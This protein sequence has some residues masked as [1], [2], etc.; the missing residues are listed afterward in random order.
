MT[1]ATV[2]L[3]LV[4]LACGAWADTLEKEKV[5]LIDWTKG[6]PFTNFLFR[7]N[8]PKLTN[9]QGDYFAYTTLVSYLQ[10]AAANHSLTL[11]SKFWLIDYKLYYFDDPLE[12]PDIKL[13][14]DFFSQN[15]SLG[16]IRLTQII[17]TPTSPSIFPREFVQAEALDLPNWQ[18]DKLPQF[19]QT[20]HQLLYTQGVNG[21]PV[22]LYFHCECGCDR[23]GEIAGSYVMRYLNYTYAQAY[24]WDQQVAGRW[25]LPNHNWAM[26][27]FCEYLFYALNFQSIGQCF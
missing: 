3:V 6:Q 1:L 7:G 9:A 15:P 20:L 5:I 23:T 24:A 25:I 2:L 27:W 8:E 16:E 4:A 11:P 19:M 26:E 10:S 17:G 21:L 12:D 13:E 14:T 22:V 18:H